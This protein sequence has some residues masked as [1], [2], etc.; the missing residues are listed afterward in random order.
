ML[1]HLSWTSYFEGVITLLIIYY[2]YIGVRYYA[3]DIKQLLA[4]TGKSGPGTKLPEQL[5]FSDAE[6]QSAGLPEEVSYEHGRYQDDDIQDADKLI[7]SV[8]K[9]ITA[10]SGTAY[11]PVKL[12]TELKAVFQEHPSLKNSPHR[13]AIN[14]LVVTECERTGVAELTEEEVDQWWGD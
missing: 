4:P 6:H 1:N 11:A 12:L 10:A 13:P 8:K 7:S 14:E 2:L 5:V 9:R 3:A